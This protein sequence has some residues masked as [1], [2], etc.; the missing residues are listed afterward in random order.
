MLKFVLPAAIALSPA[1]LS[2]QTVVDVASLVALDDID[3]VSADGEN[4]GDIEEA[5]IGPD[6]TLAAVV[7]EAGGFL[8][9]G[10]ENRVLPIERLT[11]QDGN[12]VTDLVADDIE[13]LPDWDD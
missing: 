4:I 6:G 7:V 13:S 2:A 3:V 9:I 1:A 11:F 8:G 10:D 12:F 5:L